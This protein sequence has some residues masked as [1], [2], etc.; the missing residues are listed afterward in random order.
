[1]PMNEEIKAK[2]I[3][4]LRSGEYRQGAGALRRVAST[5][6]EDRYCCLG[7]LCDLAEKAGVLTV[8]KTQFGGYRYQGESG[9]L[10][11]TV[12]TWANLDTSN[13]DVYKGSTRG[14]LA[15]LNDDGVPFSEIADMIE[16]SL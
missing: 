16:A 15:E 10:P 13:P 4:A 2:W 9:L 11:D 5:E 7:V 12:Q 6:D 14:L 1:M 8:E 3:A